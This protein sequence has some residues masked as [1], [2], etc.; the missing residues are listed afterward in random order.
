MNGN[1]I[2]TSVNNSLQYVRLFFACVAIADG[3]MNSSE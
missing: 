2:R 1:G 3:E